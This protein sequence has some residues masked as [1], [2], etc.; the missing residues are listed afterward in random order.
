MLAARLRW[1]VTNRQR[2]K[3]LADT[4]TPLAA[5]F[6]EHPEN[7]WLLAEKA[8]YAHLG[9][10]TLAGHTVQFE[11]HGTVPE[12]ISASPAVFQHCFQVGTDGELHGACRGR[13]DELPLISNSVELL[14]SHHGHE[15][16]D[17]LDCKLVEWS[18]VLA[19]N[20]TIVLF[21]FNANGRRCDAPFEGIERLRP[22]QLARKLRKFG[23]VPQTTRAILMPGNR[24]DAGL[25]RLHGIWPFT[26]NWTAGLAVGYLI[27]ARKIDNGL[28][29]LDLKRLQLKQVKQRVRG[30]AAG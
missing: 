18:R 25:Q 4:T 5:W 9:G 20:G 15:L 13:V 21:G 14:V 30:T 12:F 16:G 29:N 8:C 19:G 27:S 28:M 26:K 3:L 11:L 7:A 2:E 22:G 1:P 23:L 24:V 17:Q 6:G 10:Q